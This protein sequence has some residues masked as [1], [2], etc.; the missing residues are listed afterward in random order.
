MY[1]TAPPTFVDYGIKTIQNYSYIHNSETRPNLTATKYCSWPEA[2]QLRC[3]IHHIYTHSCPYICCPTVHV[4][5]ATRLISSSPTSR[6]MFLDEVAKKCLEVANQEK[7]AGRPV[8]EPMKKTNN[9]TYKTTVQHT[10]RRKSGRHTSY[11]NHNF[12]SNLYH[13]S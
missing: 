6:K 9:I 11:I 5:D 12:R 4:T 13:D 2:D 10:Y 1:S 7:E 8:P 3:N